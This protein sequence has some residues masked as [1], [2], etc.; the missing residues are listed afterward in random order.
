M[1]FV[2]ILEP[3]PG[4]G[5]LKFEKWPHLL[6]AIQVLSSERLVVWLKARQI[7]ASWLIAAHFLRCALFEP[8]AQLLMFSQGEEECKQLLWKTKYIYQ[9]LPPELQVK[10]KSLDNQQELA[11]PSNESWIRAL[12]STQKA[13]RSYTATKAVFDEADYHPHLD[14]NVTAVEPTLNDNGGQLILASTSN[15]DSADSLFK[16]RYRAG[17]DSQQI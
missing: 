8:G 9:Q 16:R 3:P 15:G 4:R 5:K 7:G 1:D 14:E 12:P 17:R 2:Y 10:T 11:F 13:G 6:E